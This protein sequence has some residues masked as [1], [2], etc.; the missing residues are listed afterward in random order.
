MDAVEMVEFELVD[1]EKVVDDHGRVV[2]VLMDFKKVVLEMVDFSK[3]GGCLKKM[4]DFLK[5]VYKMVVSG[6]A[7]LEKVMNVHKRVVDL[8]KV[9]W[10]LNGGG[11][12][13]D[14]SVNAYEMRSLIG[15]FL[16]RRWVSTQMVT[17]GMLDLWKVVDVYEMVVFE[18]RDSRRLIG[19]IFTGKKTITVAN[20]A[21]K[22]SQA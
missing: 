8:E 16:R 22:T 11:C 17:F 12:L 4:V 21:V 9:V 19:S 2:F 1:F 15:G 20:N 14:G 5:T 13:S 6:M 3:N 7:D 10:F 18:L